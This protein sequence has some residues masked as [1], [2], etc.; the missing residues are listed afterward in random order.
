M[1]TDRTD[2]LVL[3]GVRDD[4]AERV[5]IVG[6]RDDSARRVALVGMRD[7]SA[8]RVAGEP[9]WQSYSNEAARCDAH[10]LIDYGFLPNV[11]AAD[12]VARCI[13]LE[14]QL[15]DTLADWKLSLLESVGRHF[16]IQQDGAV[17]VGS[18]HL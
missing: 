1:R 14:L 16:V 10:W 2:T 9:L 6:M 7:D 17:H 4:S 12:P 11:S 13:P 5:A 15:P 8:G 18:V 3:V